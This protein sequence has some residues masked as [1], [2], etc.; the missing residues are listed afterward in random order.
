MENLIVNKKAKLE[1]IIDS[2][3]HS[4]SI[5]TIDNIIEFI[6]WEKHINSKELKYRLESVRNSIINSK[7]EIDL[8]IKGVQYD[9]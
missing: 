4:G 3:M 7:N 6:D 5:T 1:L 9:N 2:A 8:Q